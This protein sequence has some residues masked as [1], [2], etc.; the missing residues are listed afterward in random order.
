MTG[1]KEKPRQNPSLY[2]IINF[3]VSKDYLGDIDVTEIK[4]T[5][6][7]LAVNN[8]ILWHQYKQQENTNILLAHILVQ[9]TTPT[10]KQAV[11]AEF[12]KTMSYK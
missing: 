10:S 11:D 4:D 9:L 8:Y 6:R 5:N 2:E 7:R 12:N 3:E 1:N